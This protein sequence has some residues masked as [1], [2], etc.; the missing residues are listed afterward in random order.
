VVMALY[1]YCLFIFKKTSST[2]RTNK[3]VDK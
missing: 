2:N 3:W 1:T